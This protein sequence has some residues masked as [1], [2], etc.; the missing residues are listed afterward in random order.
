MA[1]DQV[2]PQFLKLKDDFEFHLYVAFVDSEQTIGLE[3][4]EALER[5][6]AKLRYKNFKLWIRLSEDIYAKEKPAR[7]DDK[8]IEK[9]LTPLTGKI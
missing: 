6:N 9:E 8:F 5:I 7:W 3:I 1:V 4:C 2:D